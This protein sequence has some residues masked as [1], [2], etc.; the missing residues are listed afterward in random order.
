MRRTLVVLATVSLLLAAL[1][2][3]VAAGSSFFHGRSSGHFVQFSWV[4]LDRD[5]NGDRLPP[6]DSRPFGNTHIGWAFAFTTSTGLA[7]VQGEIADLDC[8][9][10]YTP[11]FGGGGHGGFGAFVEEEPEPEPEPE[12][13]CVHIGIRQIFGE[14][15]PLTID[16]KLEFGRLGGPG[17]VVGIYGSGDDPHGGPGELIVNVPI[18]TTFTGIGPVSKSTS[19]T[20][21][22]DGTNSYTSRY[23][24]QDRQAAMGGILGPMGYAEGLSGGSMSYFKESF[25]QRTR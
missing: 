15:I 22:S 25:R 3:P 13:P 12:N 16:R 21:W 8:P 10:D 7:V 4:Q 24:S 23:V 11:P 2:S 5:A 1:A 17:V 19:T 20:S 6:L 18:N 14:N 9:T